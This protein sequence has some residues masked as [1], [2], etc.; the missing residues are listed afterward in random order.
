MKQAKVLL[1]Y[2]EGA[3]QSTPMLR[4]LIEQRNKDSLVLT[5]GITLEVRSASF[6]R[7]RGL[8]CIAVFGD[9]VAFWHSDES[10]NPDTEILNAA[11]PALATIQGPLIA[12]SSPYARRGALWETYKKHFGPEGDPSILVAQGTTRDFNPELPQSIID[13]AMDRDPPAAAA[14]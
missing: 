14:E 8:T 3:L 5:N 9:E 1:D 2:A 4:Q 12:I 13:K 10:T 6:R 7:I 11:R